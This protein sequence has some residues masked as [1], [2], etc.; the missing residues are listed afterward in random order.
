MV[1][2]SMDTVCELTIS[3][4]GLQRGKE[5]E[6]ERVDGTNRECMQKLSAQHEK[7]SFGEK[8]KYSRGKGGWR[9][10]CGSS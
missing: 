6:R 1:L 7:G 9:S 10:A 5:R 8:R 3:L 4:C 2:I